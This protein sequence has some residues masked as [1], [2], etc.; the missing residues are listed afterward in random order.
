MVCLLSHFEDSRSIRPSSLLGLYLF[1]NT[2]LWILRIRTLWLANESMSISVISTVVLTFNVATLGL[3]LKSKKSWLNSEDKGRS[4]EE[5]GGIFDRS[6]FLWINKLFRRGF[7]ESLTCNDLFPI[8]H[9]LSSQALGK[10]LSKQYKGQK[11]MFCLFSEISLSKA[12]DS[13]QFW[14]KIL[15]GDCGSSSIEA[16]LRGSSDTKAFFDGFHFRSAFAC[17]NSSD[18]FRR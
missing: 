3:E 15:L 10:R 1:S 8:D 14:K 7:H 13:P 17:R 5:L 16:F 2:L 4:P 6:F 11:G 18:I 9:S 12:A